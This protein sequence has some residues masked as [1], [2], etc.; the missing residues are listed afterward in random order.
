[1]R[2]DVRQGDSM[3]LMI[4]MRLGLLDWLGLLLAI[5]YM[6]VGVGTGMLAYQAYSNLPLA[7]LAGFFWPIGLATMLVDHTL[8][9]S[10]F[11]STF[12]FMTQ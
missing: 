6:L 7:I 2:Y 3:K 12:E 4:V 10:L 11:N 1:M 5:A 9:W 8:C